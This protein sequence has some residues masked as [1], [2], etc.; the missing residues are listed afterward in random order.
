MR[1]N[2][3]DPDPWSLW[4]TRYLKRL[5]ATGHAAKTIASRKDL[6]GR[7]AAY[8]KEAGVRTPHAVGAD[9][10][11][12]Y[13]LYRRETPNRRG[14]K[15]RPMTLNTHLLALRRF[16]DYLA[17]EGVVAPS[18]VEAVEYVKAPRT[19]PRDIPTDLEVRRMLSTAD[20]ARG[21]G[22]RDRSIMEVLY[23]TGMR[24]QELIDLTLDD[25]DLD[26]GYVRIERGK[27]AKGRV[28]PLGR[29]AADWVRRYLLA[30]R[31]ELTRG[32]RDEGWL[33]LTK[34][35]GKLDGETVRQ[36][37]AKASERAGLEKKLGPHALR[38][39]CATEMI[40]R[41]ANPW[42]VKELLGH[43]DL[44]SLDAYVKLAILDLKAAHR[45][46]H[47]RE[48]GGEDVPPVA[49]VDPEPILS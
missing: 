3:P 34:S 14:R 39:A 29:V 4:L 16:L 32:R 36:V 6:V 1:R 19:L 30:I 43:E 13:L 9:L 26:Q 10:L 21:T 45:R 38:R 40:R 35:G 11:R 22:F 37:V 27:G 44:R 24:R 17:R 12:A 28:V 41:D 5:E 25:I 8:A 20:T 23:S 15:D 42:H 48:R 31:P 46:C 49:P 47:P 33:F 18:L 2:T 7:F